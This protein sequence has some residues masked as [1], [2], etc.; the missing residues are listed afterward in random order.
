[1]G[2]S[3]CRDAFQGIKGFM[4]LLEF[5]ATQGT[6]IIGIQNVRIDFD[7]VVEPFSGIALLI[8]TGIHTS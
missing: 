5:E 1:L 4:E 8:E 6:A 7:S 2:L 3:I